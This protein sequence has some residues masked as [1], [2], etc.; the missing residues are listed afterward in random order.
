MSL[1]IKSSVMKELMK[2]LSGVENEELEYFKGKLLE[3]LEKLEKQERTALKKALLQA[4]QLTKGVDC[5]NIRTWKGKKYV[6]LANKKWARKY[7][8]EEKGIKQSLW[9]IKKKI[10]NALTC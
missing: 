8:K 6:K 9:A 7:D 3:H 2:A 5:R 4:E 10:D 1:K